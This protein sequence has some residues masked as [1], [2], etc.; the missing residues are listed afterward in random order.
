MKFIEVLENCF[1]PWVLSLFDVLKQSVKV[2]DSC[3]ACH[4]VSS[5]WKGYFR[6]F[7]L[8]IEVMMSPSTLYP[9]A[10]GSCVITASTVLDNALLVIHRSWWLLSSWAGTFFFMEETVVRN[11]S[12]S[13]TEWVWFQIINYVWIDVPIDSMLFLGADSRV[14]PWNV[15][16]LSVAFKCQ[17]R[18]VPE[19][20][21]K[22][23]VKMPTLLC[24]FFLFLYS[25]SYT[26]MIVQEDTLSRCKNAGLGWLGKSVGKCIFW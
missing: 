14:L 2:S 10:G 3:L 9:Q 13:Q 22:G 12:S 19:T 16:F 4:K 26:K 21:L 17:E 24:G 23:F 20:P 15:Y 25:I 18:T 8:P 11:Y 7:M 6:Y 1:L 5:G